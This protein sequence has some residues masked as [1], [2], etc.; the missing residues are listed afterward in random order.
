MGNRLQNIYNRIKASDIGRRMATGA[1]WSFTGTAFAKLI[2]LAAGIVCAHILGKAEYGEFGMIRS[3]INMFVVFGGAGLGLT[4]TKYISEY[5]QEHKHK[6]ASIYWLTNGFAFVSGLIVTVMILLLAPI[7]AETTLKSPYLT[8]DL[9][10]GA[11]LLFVTVINGAQTGTL[12]GLESFKSIAINTLIGSIAESLFMLVGAY[13]CGVTGAVLGFGTGFIALYV[14]NRISIRKAFQSSNIPIGHFRV[15]KEDLKILY[16]FSLP[17]A[18]SGIMVMPAYWVIRSML[19]RHNGYGELAIFE[20]ADQWKVIILFIPTAVSQIILP[21]LSSINNS[22]RNKFWKVLKLN[23]AVNGGVSLIIAL[24]VCLAS[25]FIMGM[26]GTGY[27]KSEPL[28]FLALSTV[29]SSLANV[30]GLSI[31]S[32]AKMWVGF[33]FNTLWAVMLIGFSFFFLNI[34]MGASGVAL[35]VLASY[36]VHTFFQLVYLRVSIKTQQI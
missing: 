7:L 33:S 32:R 1:F 11:L 17:A 34:D 27:D 13:Y 22:D 19:V 6:V 23:M 20:A 36:C 18:L 21:I 9:R 16:R 28:I 26:Y 3:T 14:S 24:A 8:N 4:A 5:R 2:V 15:K 35:A 29:F 10:I 25:T 12:S 30:V 31:A